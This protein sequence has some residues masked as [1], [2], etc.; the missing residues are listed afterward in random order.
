MLNDVSV[1]KLDGGKEIPILKEANTLFA[2]KQ[3]QELID[4]ANKTYIGNYT[5]KVKINSLLAVSYRF[6]G[7][8]T[9]ALQ[10]AETNVEFAKKNTNAK[11]ILSEVV[12]QYCSLC[13]DSQNVDLIHKAELMISEYYDFQMGLGLNNE[14]TCIMLT[15]LGKIQEVQKL[16]SDADKSFNDAYLSA[17]STYGN[18]NYMTLNN[19][20]H[21]QAKCGKFNEASSNF[22][23]GIN[24]MIKLVGKM[25]QNLLEPLVI[26][27][28]LLFTQKKY[29]DALNNMII[30]DQIISQLSYANNN[31]HQSIK[32]RILE[33]SKLINI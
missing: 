28:S 4:Y 8:M 27:S 10:T 23:Y 7:D 20:A 11:V 32:K 9:M 17:K 26:Y 2:N 12:I 16:Y 29:K 30:V 33:I 19:L 1:R 31:Y 18:N 25:D 5:V 13:A 14:N 22:H 6:S 3:Y 21:I 15:T 24:G